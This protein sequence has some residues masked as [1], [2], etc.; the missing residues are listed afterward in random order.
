MEDQ[1]DE[2]CGTQVSPQGAQLGQAPAYL[3]VKIIRAVPAMRDGLEGYTVI[4]PDEYT[5]WS[6]KEAFEAAYLPLGEF[7]TRISPDVLDS[8]IAEVTATKIDPKTC[9]VKSEQVT[10]FIQYATAACVSPE[11]YNEKIG[12]EI[13][14]KEIK[15]RLWFAMGFV[16]Q[17][18]RYG[19]KHSPKV[20][21]GA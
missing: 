13:A 12:T 15:D 18:G 16:L 10:G 17:W 14:M 8:I 5:S 6:P 9:L 21:Q 20:R 1:R 2:S 11:N 4:Y 7:E 19:L 3:G